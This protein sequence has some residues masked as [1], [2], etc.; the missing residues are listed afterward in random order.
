MLCLLCS[1]RD[2][3][4]VQLRGQVK[5]QGL[6]PR[7]LLSQSHQGTQHLARRWHLS[8][9][10]QLELGKAMTVHGVFELFFFFFSESVYSG[11]CAAAITRSRMSVA[12]KHRAMCHFGRD[13]L[14]ITLL[15]VCLLCI[16][17]PSV[18]SIKCIIAHTNRGQTVCGGGERMSCALSRL[19]PP[20]SFI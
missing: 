5:A 6:R 14:A 15:S 1:L 8:N 9:K 13:V 3:I 2:E 17:L 18:K 20:F 10:H 7:H 4:A 11:Q 16:F 19:P 12:V